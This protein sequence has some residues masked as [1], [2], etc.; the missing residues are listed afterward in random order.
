[1]QSSC[2]PVIVCVSHDKSG[3]DEEEIHSE[4]SV[5]DDLIA[6][7][8]SISFKQMEEQHKQ[9]RDSEQTVKNLIPWFRGQISGG[10]IYYH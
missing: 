6:K 5:C 2:S 4:I 10:S 9:G 1:M 8:L 3:Q 7:S